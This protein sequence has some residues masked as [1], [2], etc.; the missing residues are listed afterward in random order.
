[1]SGGNVRFMWIFA[2]VPWVGGV[3]RQW[4]CLQRQFSAFSLVNI[5]SLEIRP[6]LLYSS[7]ESLAGFSVI[8][9]CMTLNGYF[10]LNSVLAPVCLA[11]LASETASFENNSMK[12]NNAVLVKSLSGFICFCCHYSLFFYFCLSFCM[13][14]TCLCVFCS[15]YGPSCLQ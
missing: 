10:A 5:S 11:A 3:K 1:V 2:G 12:T 4:G 13:F 6:A 14:V 9:K 7:M 8:P 15:F